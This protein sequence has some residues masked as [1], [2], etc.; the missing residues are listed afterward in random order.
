MRLTKNVEYI[1]DSIAKAG[2]R[3]DIVGGPVRD[4]LLAKEPS[5]YDI[6][7]SATPSRIKEIFSGHKTVDTGIKHGTVTLILNGEPYE[8]TTYRTDGEYRDFRHPDSVSFTTRIEEDLARRDFTVNAMAYNKELGLTDIFGGREDL[9]KKII[10]AVGDPY[11]RFSEDALRILRAVRFSSVLGFEI[12]ENTAR[13]ARELAHLLKHVSAERI[14]S[15]W[16]KLIAG[17]NA[18]SVLTKYRD[19]IAVFMPQ[20]INSKL[21]DEEKFKSAEPAVR[22]LSL[23]APLE[24][25]YIL[26]DEAMRAL[27][28]PT[29][30][31]G[32]GAAVLSSLGKFPEKSYGEIGKMLFHL[33]KECSLTL[34]KLEYL[35]GTASR[36]RETEILEYLRQGKPYRISDLALDGS[37]I[38]S[39]GAKGREIGAVLNRLMLAVLDGRCENTKKDLTALAVREISALPR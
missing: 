31:R 1:L 24:N 13:A 19:I 6:T 15:E 14:Y 32:D 2:D 5:D 22:T 36:T 28:S 16:T 17:D 8:I 12:E 3:A 7:T 21:P 4:F 11:T 10:R 29:K 9:E 25:A 18:Y 38:S 34:A 27:R 35:L 30:L 39:F 23:F 37:D 33:G 20:V 26:Y